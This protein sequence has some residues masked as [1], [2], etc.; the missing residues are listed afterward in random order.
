M[1]ILYITICKKN[2]NYLIYSNKNTYILFYG[3][4]II[5]NYRLGTIS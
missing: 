3:I 2:E 5:S 1:Y 4:I